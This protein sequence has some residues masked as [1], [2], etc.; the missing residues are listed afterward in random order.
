MKLG[1]Q[2]NVTSRDARVSNAFPNLRLVPVG[3]CGINMPVTRSQG[4]FYGDTD[5][6][7]L[8]LPGAQA[9]CRDFITC[10]QGEGSP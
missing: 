2:P 1:R 10:I 6:I 8:R 5:F 4:R 3:G 9:D 7:R